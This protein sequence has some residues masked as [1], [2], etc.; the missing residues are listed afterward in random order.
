MVDQKMAAL[1]RSIS[2]IGYVG[3]RVFKN[4]T[5]VTLVAGRW[6]PMCPKL[7]LAA[8]SPR[9]TKWFFLLTFLDI[10]HLDMGL[11][12]SWVWVP[13]SI[14][15][16]KVCVASSCLSFSSFFSVWLATFTFGLT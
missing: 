9:S 5:L 1:L 7:P 13:A 11:S 10:G 6:C 12:R 15:R 2:E 14:P 16:F 4:H 3:H 8:G